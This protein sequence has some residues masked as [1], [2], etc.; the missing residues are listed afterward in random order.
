M[1]ALPRYFLFTL[2]HQ[3]GANLLQHGHHKLVE[4]MMPLHIKIGCLRGNAKAEQFF[5]QCQIAFFGIGVVALQLPNLGIHLPPQVQ[6]L[7]RGMLNA[8]VARFNNAR[9][10][11]DAELGIARRAVIPDAPHKEGED[12]LRVGSHELG[13]VE[14]QVVV[15]RHR[16]THIP[17]RRSIA[18]QVLDGVCIGVKDIGVVQNFF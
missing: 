18:L 9:E 1:F 5:L 4:E 7:L 2:A 12:G 10:V 6:Q 3:H 13:E 11:G 16:H 14:H 8:E 17:Q 15:E